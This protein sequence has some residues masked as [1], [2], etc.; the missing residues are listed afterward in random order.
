MPKKPMWT[1]HYRHFL[2]IDTEM[3][4]NQ[5]RPTV[6]FQRRWMECI[7]EDMR[8]KC[9]QQKSY[10][11]IWGFSYAGLIAQFV[12]SYNLVRPKADLDPQNFIN[13]NS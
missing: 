12:K 4:N 7:K 9:L 6:S 1:T 13:E 2:Q 8:E 10:T 5:L 3:T 11:T